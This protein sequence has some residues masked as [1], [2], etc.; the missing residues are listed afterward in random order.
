MY[1]YLGPIRGL[2]AAILE[3]YEECILLE[4]LPKH[5][6][7]QELVCR[8]DIKVDTLDKRS[9]VEQSYSKHSF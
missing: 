9:A 7:V 1:I 2:L 5:H 6:K 8:E 4:T 3:E